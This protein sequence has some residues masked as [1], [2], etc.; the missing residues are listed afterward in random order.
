[1]GRSRRRAVLVAVL[2]GALSVSLAVPGNAAPAAR[3]GP[4]AGDVARSK[5]NVHERAQSVQAVQGRIAATRSRLNAL[6]TAAEAAFESYDAARV[7]EHRASGRVDAARDVVAIAGQQVG[8]AR[9]RLG[10]FV[11]AAYMSGGT[12]SRLQ[13]LALSEDPGAFL[14]KVNALGVLGDR[15]RDAVSALAGARAYQRAVEQQARRALAARRK[16]TAAAAAARRS[17]QR[18]VAGQQRLLGRLQHQSAQLV[19]ALK[20]AK[21]Q[22]SKIE[23][24]RAQALAASRAA[25]RARHAASQRAKAA[26]DK[27]AAARRAAL[28]AE[29]RRSQHAST[30]TGAVHSPTHQQ[31]APR[32]T[33]AHSKPSSPPAPAPRRRTPARSSSGGSSAGT[34]SSPRP[35]SSG[36]TASTAT[37]QQAVQ[38][39]RRELGK[40]YVWGASGPGAFDCSGLVMYVYGKVGVALDHWTGDQWHDGAHVSQAAL[41]PGDLVFFS[42][43]GT[44]AGIHHVGIYAG[45][46][47]MIEAPYTGADV[48]ISSAF[49]PDYVGAVRP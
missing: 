38:W 21:A 16:A 8:A 42:S 23:H 27:A 9:G 10:K 29:H 45:G 25:A 28:A 4:S 37:E 11:A 39:A 22:A 43:D 47:Q 6:N 17:A 15:R 36:G 41:R 1:M 34:S 2:G 32:S 49:R 26:A 20:T 44:E 5:A 3:H 12:L 7:R 24:A 35:V 30:S 14:D 18:K 33:P 46:G 13:T 19:T 31:A 40:P 48:R